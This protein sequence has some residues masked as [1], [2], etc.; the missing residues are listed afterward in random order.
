MT[1]RIGINPLTWTNDDMPE[2]GAETPLETGLAEGAEAGYEGFE[3]GNKFPRD[4]AIL[5]PILKTFG[6]DLVSGW[7]SSNLL[8][9]SV[10]EEIAAM[11]PHLHLLRS[12]GCNVMV[13]AETTG[14]VHGEME[15]PVST[16]P[17]MNEAQWALFTGRLT[18]MAEYLAS[19]GVHM[20]YHHHMGTVVESQEDIDRMM[21]GT[22][23]AV[24]SRPS[25]GRCLPV[26]PRRCPCGGDNPCARLPRPGIRP[27]A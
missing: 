7:Y 4:P 24:R 11:Q 8:E 17:C 1:I 14:A 20:G 10:D 25:G 6:L 26:I 15:T 13:F 2:L 22:G 12:L 3:L 19:E 5:G 21:A 16:R 9:R 23:P 18:Q 27:S